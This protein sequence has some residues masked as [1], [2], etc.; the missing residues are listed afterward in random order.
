[1]AGIIY[2]IGIYWK[3]NLEMIETSEVEQ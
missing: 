1:L 2:V 3:K